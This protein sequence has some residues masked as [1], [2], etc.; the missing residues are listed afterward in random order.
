MYPLLVGTISENSR[1]DNVIHAS[2]YRRMRPATCS[3]S[4]WTNVC[5]RGAD[6]QIP[7]RLCLGMRPIQVY[8]GVFRSLIY[9]VRG[10]LHRH[11]E[12]VP[13]PRLRYV[14]V[15][16]AQVDYL[17]KF[18]I[19]QVFREIVEFK[20]RR[21]VGLDIFSEEMISWI[22]I[23]FFFS[24]FFNAQKLIISRIWMF[25]RCWIFEQRAWFNLG[26][27]RNQDQNF[28]RSIFIYVYIFLCIVNY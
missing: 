4:S 14:Q 28:F 26:G 16:L 3:T 13:T 15:S 1:P 27:F 18:G 10:A 11:R 22:W 9:S 7:P 23:F 24:F 19:A 2:R 21:E 6:P 20:G 17:G 8:V 25:V 5:T 12:T